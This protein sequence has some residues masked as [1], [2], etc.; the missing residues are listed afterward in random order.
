MG[1]DIFKGNLIYCYLCVAN[2]TICVLF[3]LRFLLPPFLLCYA[4]L[5]LWVSWLPPPMPSHSLTSIFVDWDFLKARTSPPVIGSPLALFLV[6]SPKSLSD[7]K[8]VWDSVSSS[9]LTSG[10]GMEAHTECRREGWCCP[11]WTCQQRT[12]SSAYRPVSQTSRKSKL[13][14]S[15]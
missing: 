2:D 9:D 3:T 8:L 12:F 7:S 14:F 11:E 4:F 15:T 5:L 10:T 6:Q 1:L 13:S